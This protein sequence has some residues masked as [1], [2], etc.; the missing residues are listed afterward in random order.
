MASAPVTLTSNGEPALAVDT[1]DTS[2]N[3][4]VDFGFFQPL[5]LGNL[6]FEDVANN[7]VYDAA[8]DSPLVGA[9]VAL[10]TADGTTPAVDVDGVAVA[11]QTTV[12]DGLYLFPNLAPGAYV[13]QVSAPAGYRS[14]TDIV[15][16]LTP[17]NNTND[18]DNGTAQAGGAVLSAPVT[19]T[20]GGEPI[21]D[22]DADTNTNLSV[23]FGFYPLASLGD[24]VWLDTNKDG[25]Q[26][27]GESGVAG[28]NVQLYQPG[29]DG[30]GRHRRRRAGGDHHHWRERRLPVP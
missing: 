2:G 3:L 9:S 19:L 22:G 15:G 10:F 4:T 17:D 14:S 7:G 5:W 28:V 30:I 23:D 24:Y 1:D 25:M 12:A 27:K 6:V 29:L 21:T 18:D 20:S 11:N 13:V 16:S 8:T 26:D